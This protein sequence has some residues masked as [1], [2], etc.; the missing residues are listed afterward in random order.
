MVQSIF[1]IRAMSTVIA[2]VVLL[3]FGRLID[4]VFK[5]LTDERVRINPRLHK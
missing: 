3:C 1:R 2:M 5:M 4:W